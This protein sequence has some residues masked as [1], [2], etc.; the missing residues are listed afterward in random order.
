MGS[1]I[2]GQRRDVLRLQPPAQVRGTRSRTRIRAP[3][4]ILRSQTSLLELSRKETDQTE[5]I[6]IIKHPSKPEKDQ[7]SVTKLNINRLKLNKKKKRG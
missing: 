6:S 3:A 4:P 1:R 7:S 2:R 5:S